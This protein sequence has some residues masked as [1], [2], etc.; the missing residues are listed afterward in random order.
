MKRALLGADDIFPA[1]QETPRW[2]GRSE[3]LD[4]SRVF[5][6]DTPATAPGAEPALYVHGL[7]GSSTNWTDLAGLLSGRLVRL[8]I[9]LPV[10]VRS[11]PACCY[12]L[13]A[14]AD[15]VIRRFA[16][17]GRGPVHLFVHSLGGAISVR[18]AGT[19]PDLV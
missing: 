15:R 12:P 19:R 18:V 2:P 5:V 10:F 9:Y 3:M 1:D 13:V 6:R 8:L 16:H 4:G 11:D 14:L 17:P 7:G